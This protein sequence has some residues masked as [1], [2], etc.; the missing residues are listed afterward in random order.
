MPAFERSWKYS[1]S[2]SG[3]MPNSWSGSTRY[4]VRSMKR[5]RPPRLSFVSPP[6]GWW[7]MAVLR[8]SRNRKLRESYGS[9]LVL[10]SPPTLVLANNGNRPIPVILNISN[11]TIKMPKIP[12]VL[13]LG[14]THK[15]SVSIGGVKFV[16]IWNKFFRQFNLV[17]T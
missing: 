10:S 15:R 3:D 16:H 4:R 5:D 13:T 11:S 14:N 17:H 2:I 6:S 12:H 9:F 1:R 8:Y 7:F